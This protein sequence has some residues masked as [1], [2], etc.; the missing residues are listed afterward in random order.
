[1]GVSFPKK[2]EVKKLLNVLNDWVSCSFKGIKN[3]DSFFEYFKLEKSKF[4]TCSP[5]NFYQ[6]GLRYESITILY[7][8]IQSNQNTY[9]NCFINLSG[10]GCRQF[11][12][13]Q[14][15]KFNWLDWFGD[16]YTHFCDNDPN[17]TRIDIALDIKD[18][19]CPTM[20]KI[21][22]AV[23]NK[24]YISN[25]RREITTKGS[26]E[27][28][29]FGS[30]TSD[31]RIRIYNKA[32]ERGFTDGEKWI[33]FE[34]QLR[35]QAALRFLNHLFSDK[36]TLGQA[37]TDFLNANFRFTTKSKDTLTGHHQDRLLSS[38]WW[39]K[40]IKDAG[41]ITKCNVPGIEYNL[42]RAQLFIA[43]QV[44]PT[45]S[46]I[47][48]AYGGDL[49][50]V[51]QILSDNEHRLKDKHFKLIE[52]GQEKMNRQQKVEMDLIKLRQD[53]FG[54]DKKKILQLD[55][56]SLADGFEFI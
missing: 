16:I 41:E 2:V 35:N 12:T 28:C 20:L 24:K 53:L 18:N 37:M 5:Y 17:F 26:E 46:A 4:K 19:S 34:Y 1:M 15:D 54:D 29:F 14:G 11:E 44:A 36:M 43:N 42:S 30:P 39:A 52:E 8:E 51:M 6:Y 10:Q 55:G 48:K 56:I 9:Y 32:L 49:S 27:F 50:V 22:D 23:E 47:I 33:R 38:P 21:I 45:L 3:L 40:L 7:T 25:F 13:I 31:T